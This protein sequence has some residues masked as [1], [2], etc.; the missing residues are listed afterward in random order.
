MDQRV[1]SAD[2][3]AQLRQGIGLLLS[4][5]S[6]LQMA[7]ENDPKAPTYFLH[8]T[9]ARARAHTDTSIYEPR[10]VD[11]LE[12]MLDE[13]MLSLNTEIGDGSIE[14]IAEKLM[15]MHEE[16]LEGNYMS[17]E[18]LKEVNPHA[19]AVQH[20]RQAGN[21]DDESSDEDV[22]LED[23]DSAEMAVDAPESESKSNQMDI[24]VEEPS[25]ARTAEAEDGWT[26]VAPRRNRGRRQ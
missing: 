5:W 22:S 7:V 20:I 19:A 2:A 13:V 18:S 3:A 21:D 1:L 10:Y 6:A 23:D 9:H 15:V 4:R 12:D 24:I 16:C 26:V 14:E 11:E 17:I 25:P 8:F